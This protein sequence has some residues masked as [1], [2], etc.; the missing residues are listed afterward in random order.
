[1]GYASYGICVGGMGKKSNFR[2]MQMSVLVVL[3]DWGVLV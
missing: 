3:L 2:G 1:V